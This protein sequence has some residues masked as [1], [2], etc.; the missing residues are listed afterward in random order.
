[1]G[2]EL[3]PDEVLAADQRITAWAQ[4]LRKAGLDGGMDVLPARAFL[5]CCWARTPVPATTPAAAQTAPG[6]ARA[7]QGRA[8]RTRRP[9]PGRRAARWRPG[10]PGG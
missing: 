6:R 8:A 9:R 10:S 4:E 1:M 3:P 2:C 5:T 7:G